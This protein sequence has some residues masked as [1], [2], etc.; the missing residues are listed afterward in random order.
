L[1][2][3]MAREK[4]LNDLVMIANIF[5][6]PGAANRQRIRMNNYKT[7]RAAIR[8]TL[9]NRPTLEEILREKEAARHPF[10]YSP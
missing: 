9:E 4:I 3:V 7:M 10:R 8:K 5:V 1:A 6:H 2:Q